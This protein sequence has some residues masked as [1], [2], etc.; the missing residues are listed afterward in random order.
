MEG[1]IGSREGCFL[2]VVIKAYLD[3]ERM[4]VAKQEKMMLQERSERRESKEQW[5]GLS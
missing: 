1:H 5:K 3:A 4:D 2:L